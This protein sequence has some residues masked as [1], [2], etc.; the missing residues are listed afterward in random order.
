MGNAY[1]P[2]AK[3][4]KFSI[5]N[6]LKNSQKIITITNKALKPRTHLYYIL[7]SHLPVVCPYFTSLCHSVKSVKMG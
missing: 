2:L 6:E 3:L 4:R 7:L 5:L 1:Q